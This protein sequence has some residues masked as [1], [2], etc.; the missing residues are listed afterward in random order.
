MLTLITGLPNAG[1]TT[2]SARYS[3]VLHLDDYRSVGA[4][5]RAAGEITGDVVVEGALGKAASRKQL[6]EAC[7][8]Q[9]PKICIWLDTPYEEC[10]RRENRNRPLAI[11]QVHH[12]GFQPPSL[13]EG[14]DEIIHIGGLGVNR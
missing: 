6:I 14:W 2:Y 12:Q 7:T 9:S 1:K 5:C 11:V 3:E 8:T 4:C 10:L 13:E